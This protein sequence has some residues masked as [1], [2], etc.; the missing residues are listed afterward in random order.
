[1][2]VP[3]FALQSLYSSAYSFWNT[4]T[5]RPP[6]PHTQVLSFAAKNNASSFPDL[7]GPKRLKNARL[8]RSLF[9]LSFFLLF[10]FFIA[11]KP[12]DYCKQTQLGFQPSISSTVLPLSHSSHNARTQASTHKNTHTQ[13]LMQFVTTPQAIFFHALFT[14]FLHRF[15]F[16]TTRQFCD[17]F[18]YFFIFHFFSSHCSFII[19][20]INHLKILLFLPFARTLSSSSFFFFSFFSFWL[21]QYFPLATTFVSPYT[22]ESTPHPV[23]WTSPALHTQTQHYIWSEQH[24]QKMADRQR[25][26]RSHN[27]CERFPCFPAPTDEPTRRWLITVTNNQSD[28]SSPMWW[29]TNTHIPTHPHTH[30]PTHTSD[31]CCSLSL[32]TISLLHALILFIDHHHHHHHTLRDKTLTPH[33]PSSFLLSRPK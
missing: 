28:W 11:E 24:T 16:F 13:K 10:S 19:I 5:E 15:P 25:H 32:T 3:N 18:L 9:S 22:P 14:I 2:T 29:Y 4:L 8:R 31:H 26:K 21:L 17:I 7:I 1:M 23:C 30:T 6:P 20:I 27:V 33:T 12:T